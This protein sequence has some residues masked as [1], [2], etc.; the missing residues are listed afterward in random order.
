MYTG[1][2][3]TVSF[4]VIQFGLCVLLFRSGIVGWLERL[5]KR[6]FK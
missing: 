4:L 6:N 1:S 2:P 5:V 3:A